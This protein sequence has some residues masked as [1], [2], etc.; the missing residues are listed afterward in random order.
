MDRSEI[1]GSIFELL[2]SGL[3]L[4]SGSR[5]QSIAATL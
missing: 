1:R 2:R 4:C 3:E 5:S